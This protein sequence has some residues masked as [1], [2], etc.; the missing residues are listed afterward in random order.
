MCIKAVSCQKATID[1]DYGYRRAQEALCMI[2]G[3]KWHV[4]KYSDISFNS[5]IKDK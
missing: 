1:Y 4:D 5:T 2:N 3:N